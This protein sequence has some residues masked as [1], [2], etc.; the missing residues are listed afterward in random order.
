MSAIE[1]D[2]TTVRVPCR[3]CGTII[4]IDFD[5]CDRAQAEELVSKLDRLPRECPG[6]HVEL[7]GWRWLWRLDEAVEAFY[8]PRGEA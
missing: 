4:G 1:L 3:E 8:G 7:S 6:F 2:G 5:G